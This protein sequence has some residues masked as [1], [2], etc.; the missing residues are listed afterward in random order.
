[1]VNRTV[2]HSD[3]LHGANEPDPSLQ[4]DKELNSAEKINQGNVIGEGFGPGQQHD[5]KRPLKDGAHT[6]GLGHQWEVGTQVLDKGAGVKA[7]TGHSTGSP[8]ICWS[9]RTVRHPLS[10]RTARPFSF[11]W[12][13]ASM[14][15]NCKA[16]SQL[17][18]KG[19]RP[20]VGGTISG[21]VVLVL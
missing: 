15:S 12:G 18:I 19:F 7:E 11:S 9:L 3:I 4:P 17:V 20:L 10:L 1:V 21:L 13:S 6:L 2:P 14:R 8:G 16:F 5:N